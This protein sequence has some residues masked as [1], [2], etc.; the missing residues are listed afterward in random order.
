MTANPPSIDLQEMLGYKDYEM[1]NEGATRFLYAP[2]GKYV[3]LSGSRGSESSMEVVIQSVHKGLFSYSLLETLRTTGPV[4]SYREL[5]SR[6]KQKVESR[7]L[8]QHPQLEFSPGLPID[9]GFLGA[10]ITIFQS[11]YEVH[12]NGGK[13]E[14][15]AGALNGIPPVD[16]DNPTLFSLEDGGTIEV[17]EVLASHSIISKMPAERDQNTT[18]KVLPLQMARHKLLLGSTEGN[19]QEGVEFFQKNLTQADSN[20][21]NFDANATDAQYLIACQN[22]SVWVEI[23]GQTPKI[24]FAFTNGL[25]DLSMSSF[26]SQLHKIANWQYLR[27]LSNPTTRFN[28]ADLELTIY[29]ANAAS[30]NPEFINLVYEKKGDQLEAPTIRGKLVNKTNESIW[31]AVLFLDAEFG[32]YHDL[33]PVREIRGLGEVWLSVQLP[34]HAL[35]TS[36]QIHIPHDLLTAGVNNVNEYLKV[37]VSNEEFEVFDL[38]QSPLN[39]FDPSPQSRAIGFREDFIRRQKWWS[40]Q[41]TTIEIHHPGES[42]VIENNKSLDSEIEEVPSKLL[43]YLAIRPDHSKTSPDIWEQDAVISDILTPWSLKTGLAVQRNANA[44]LENLTADI[45]KYRDSLVI[46]YLRKT[47][48]DSLFAEN[49]NNI[50]ALSRI[51]GRCPLLKLVVLNGGATKGQVNALLEAGVP[52]VVAIGVPVTQKTA[53][54]FSNYLFQELVENQNTLNQAFNAAYQRVRAQSSDFPIQLDRISALQEGADHEPSWG[55]FFREKEVLGWK[56]FAQ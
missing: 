3:L 14:L 4:I 53:T 16:R 15:N 43:V 40:A 23:P 49:T 11:P 12:F 45:A 9:L 41:T 10:K 46:F 36:I 35:S 27:D 1:I 6:V 29:A 38:I 21:L 47:A 39:S 24:R 31:V 13:W 17:I 8:N 22:E 28:P 50:Q 37:L 56:L 32:I 51:L 52:C 19:N 33:L 34:N 25:N 48:E 54:D 42:L 20:V 30:T 26:K 2:S 5:I 44:S 7:N 55:L 18:H